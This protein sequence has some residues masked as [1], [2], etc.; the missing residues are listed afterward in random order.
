MNKGI[1]IVFL[2]AFAAVLL[3]LP[4]LS[5]YRHFTNPQTVDPYENRRLAELPELNTQTITTT[6]FADLE[7]YVKDHFFQRSGWMRLNTAFELN[8]LR[9]RIVAE[10]IPSS[11]AVVPYIPYTGGMSSGERAAQA[12]QRAEDYRRVADALTEWGG[13]FLFVG[14]PSQV[15]AQSEAYPAG[16]YNAAQSQNANMDAL[17]GAM[18]NRGLTVLDMREVYLAEG[19]YDPFYLKTDHHQT[20]EGALVEYRAIFQRLNEMGVSVEPVDF[21][22]RTLTNPVL[23]SR[24][25]RLYGLSELSDTLN[26]A[27]PRVEIPFQYSDSRGNTLPENLCLLPENTDDP[28]T[29]SIYMGGDMP[30]SVLRTDR[31]EKPSALIYGDSYT[32][33]LESLF[34]TGFNETRS[35][36]L[37]YYKGSLLEY[38]QIYKPDTVVLVRDSSVMLNADGNGRIGTEDKS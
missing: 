14:V 35:L 12:E 19:G 26:I 9:Q 29:Y 36:D 34:Y 38:I 6:F 10:V 25:R 3:G 20:I 24:S 33:I 1:Q 7:T 27:V 13:V 32:N 21:E 17:L 23:G 15:I 22:R 16:L 8:V 30:E 28:V 18:E 11:E 5:A 31:P 4:A 2:A 37:R